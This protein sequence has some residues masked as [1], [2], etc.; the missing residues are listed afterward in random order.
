MLN[1][2]QSILKPFA[3]SSLLLGAALVALFFASYHLVQIDSKGDKVDSLRYQV[4]NLHKAI[5]R[6]ETGQRGYLL[7]N[8]ARFLD[9]YNQGREEIEAIF[10]VLPDLLA[11]CPELQPGFK[12]IREL[13]D[14]KLQGIETSI[15]IEMNSG[16]YA[17]H[18]NSSKIGANIMQK[19]DEQINVLDAQ[20]QQ[21]KA[22]Y[23]LASHRAL[24]QTVGGAAVLL[25]IIIGL[26]V[27]GY[28]KTIKLFEIAATSQSTAEAMSHDAYH[29]MLTGL[30]NRRYFDSYLKR[31]IFLSR[32]SGQPFSLLYLDL[33]G[34][35]QI[36]D[37]QG[38]EGGDEALKYA[39]ERFKDALRE[40]DFL[41]RSGGDEFVVLINNYSMPSEIGGLANRII[42]Y[43]NQPFTINGEHQLIGVS[44]GV[45]SYPVDGVDDESLMAAADQAMY[46]AK[47]KGKNQVVFSRA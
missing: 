32:R 44:I 24:K 41:A 5:I 29:D 27:A 47:K 22:A 3:I 26:F 25:L 7:T 36:N 16:S 28:R 46:E 21:K 31:Q 15:Q 34:F 10:S 14:V 12:R 1:Y 13:T 40:S 17:P 30:P 42:R 38:H 43:V 39:T 9:A 33:D 37:H 6:A 19:I 18:L 4:L 20:L 23:T 11:D 2:K 45:S 8:N 35:K